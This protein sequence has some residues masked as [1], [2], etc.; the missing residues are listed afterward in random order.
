VIPEVDQAIAVA[1]QL[2]ALDRR[3]PGDLLFGRY[4]FFDRFRHFRTWVNGPAGQH[5]GLAPIPDGTLNQRMLRRTIAQ[6][7]AYRPG[8]LLA[9]KTLFTYVR[10]KEELVFS[11]E[12]N[13]L[14]AVVA[15]ARNR[16]IGQTPLVAAASALLA[17]VDDDDPSGGL[18]GFHRMVGSSPA[19]RSRLRARYDETEDKITEALTA[20][21]DGPR[22]RPPAAWWR[23]RSWSWSARSRAKRCACSSKSPT[24]PRMRGMRRCASGYETRLAAWRAGSRPPAVSQSAD[25]VAV[26]T[27]RGGSLRRRRPSD[28]V[29]CPFAH[30]STPWRHRLRIWVPRP[31]R[32]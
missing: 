5:L 3:E 18:E 7:I 25:Y 27:P 16:R 30:L 6:E 26:S 4:V 2:L 24:R 31:A 13:V 11:D 32:R 1:E 9:A 19:I 15:A 12:P 21:K 14:D 10:S 20:R 29:S 17:A 23:R 8:G 22:E 28:E